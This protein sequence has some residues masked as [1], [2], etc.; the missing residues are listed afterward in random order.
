MFLYLLLLLNLLGVSINAYNIKQANISVYL[1]G[2][3]YCNKDNYSIMKLDGPANG[4]ITDSILYNVKTDIQG[5]IGYLPSS[6][7]IYTVI[8][9]SSSV[10]NW[11]DD[12]EVRKIPYITYEECNCNVHRGFY[13]SALSVSN[14]T[15]EV[16]K[17]LQKRYPYYSIIMTGHSLGAAIAQLLGMEL[18]KEGIKVEIYNFGQPRIGD[19]NYGDFVN[20]I[21][22]NKLWRFTHYQD[23]VPHIPPSKGMNFLHSCKEIY[24]DEKGILHTCS[25]I[26]C[27]DPNCAFQHPLY[28]TNWDD[29]HIYLGHPMEC[30]ESIINYI[31]K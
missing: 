2:A 18:E 12:L 8:R 17:K 15:I 7:T 19:D 26:N 28:K 29:H 31:T 1:S 6:K 22:K 20:T 23:M 25:D 9:G 27:E 11:L 16:I 21:I 4:F 24:E 10:L 5:Y 14:K 30:F 13:N 3:A